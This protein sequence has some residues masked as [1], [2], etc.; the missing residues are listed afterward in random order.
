MKPDQ[1]F[2]IKCDKQIQYFEN[3]LRISLETIFVQVKLSEYYDILNVQA[4][5]KKDKKPSKT[6]WLCPKGCSDNKIQFG[7][8]C[9]V[10]H[11]DFMYFVL[12]NRLRKKEDLFGSDDEPSEMWKCKKCDNHNI[13]V[14]KACSKCNTNKFNLEQ[15]IKEEIIDM[16]REYNWI[17]YFCSYT[18]KYLKNEQC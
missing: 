1:E 17:C 3:K 12:V 15:Q 7:K 10:C 14:K 5:I 4:N 8:K 18:N 2:C 13:D 9:R 11:E 6:Y 16:K